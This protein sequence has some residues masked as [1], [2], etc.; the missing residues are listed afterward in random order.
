MRILS[1]LAFSP[2][3]GSN[4]PHNKNYSK[5]IYLYYHSVIGIAAHLIPDDAGDV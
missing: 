3:Q 4:T 2:R 5:N 1:E